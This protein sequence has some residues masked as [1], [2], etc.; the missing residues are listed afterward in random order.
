MKKI[1]NVVSPL[2]AATLGLG[3]GA[4]VAQSDNDN[5]WNRR[6]RAPGVVKAVGFD[7]IRE[8]ARYSFDQSHCNP[9][10]QVV[11]DN[12]K[13]GCRTNAWDPK[14][15]TSGKGSVRFDVLP[16]SRPGGGGNLAIPFGDYATSQFGA[17]Q[18]FWVSWRQRMDARY[19]QGYRREGGKGLTTFKQVIIAQGDMPL[20]GAKTYPGNACSEAQVV[21]VSS[22]PTAQPTFPMGYI[23]CAKYLPF[24]Q[25]GGRSGGSRITT[26]QN[27]RT[28]G[29]GAFSCISN[30]RNME[31][32]G[33]MEYRPD[34]WTTYMVRLKL[35]PEGKAVS[36][37]YKKEQPGYVDSTYE[38]YAARPGEDFVLLHRQTGLVIPKGQYY[39][40]GDTNSR[41]SYKDGWGPG[42]AHPEARFGK[43]WLLSFMTG[44]DSKEGT[45]KASTWYDEV[46][47]SRCRIAAPGHPIPRECNPSRDGKAV[48][49]GD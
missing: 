31:R 32:S 26:Y 23:E 20:P 49:N 34:E 47:I 10:Y 2:L 11:V 40:G 18:E 12:K 16:R 48:V 13:E 15:K 35:G 44:K 37:I 41:S 24:A 17:N 39:L 28:L 38:L 27:M 7:D 5:D 22:E 25:T 9:E 46:I 36:S 33:C 8:W 14:V 45:E 30:P 1:E 3:T 4:G 6:S 29:E 43:L 21:V 19:L 42:D